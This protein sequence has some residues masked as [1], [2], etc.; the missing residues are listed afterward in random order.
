MQEIPRTGRGIGSLVPAA[1][2]GAVPAGQRPEAPPK[3]IVVL[4]KMFAGTA[5]FWLFHCYHLRM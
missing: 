1:R 5:D 3:L 4:N 2:A